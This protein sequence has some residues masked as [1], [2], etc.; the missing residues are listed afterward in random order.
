MMSV[1]SL[2]CLTFVFLDF[3]P[4]IRWLMR[5]AAS[6]EKGVKFGGGGDCPGVVRAEDERRVKGEVPEDF[7]SCLSQFDHVLTK[8]LKCA[9]EAVGTGCTSSEKNVLTQ[10]NFTLFEE[11]FLKD[12]QEIAEKVGE[13][14]HNFMRSYFT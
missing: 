2:S 7:I 14:Y 10:R 12:F 11:I 9:F 6:G 13:F 4:Y 8:T 5:P 3:I 1:P